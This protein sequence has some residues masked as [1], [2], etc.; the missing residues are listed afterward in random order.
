MK[1]D[2]NNLT[3]NDI[4]QIYSGKPGCCC[5]CLGTHSYNEIHL[6]ESSESHGYEISSATAK[7]ATNRSL[8]RMLNL[9][10]KNSDKI[11]F[12]DTCISFETDTRLYVIYFCKSYIESH[13]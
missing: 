10:K 12:L 1:F 6:K 13:S 3:I 5:G 9:F 4:A 2:I 8:N 11:E 7:I